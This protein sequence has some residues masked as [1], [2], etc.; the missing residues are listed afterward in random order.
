MS[1]LGRL[2]LAHGAGDYREFVREIRVQ[3]GD[4]TS[5]VAAV[6]TY[7]QDHDIVQWARE[8]Y[9]QGRL[10]DAENQPWPQLLAD[11]R[12]VAWQVLS[13]SSKAKKLGNNTAYSIL[14]DGTGIDG[15]TVF[16][17]YMGIATVPG[18]IPDFADIPELIASDGLT[19]GCDG[20]IE[21]TGNHPMGGQPRT[22]YF[23]ILV[24][25]SPAT[26]TPYVPTKAPNIIA[27]TPR[28]SSALPSAALRPTATPWHPNESMPLP[29]PSIEPW[30]TWFYGDPTM[31]VPASEPTFDFELPV[32]E[33]PSRPPTD[34]PVLPPTPRVTIGPNASPGSRATAMDEQEPQAVTEPPTTPCGKG[35]KVWWYVLA[36]VLLLASGFG[37]VLI[38]RKRKAAN[39][40]GI[41]E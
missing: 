24:V 40:G 4:E 23:F 26:P 31:T 32:L 18:G 33:L 9:M 8:N 34:A 11:K 5:A 1:L 19:R 6:K 15:D 28:P 3:P 29:L 7:D 21:G 17:G 12:I 16:L 10:L 37:G 35:K 30:P 13:I 14:Y 22:A 38:W 36:M 41:N 27:Q 25:R 20:L 2:A 39:T